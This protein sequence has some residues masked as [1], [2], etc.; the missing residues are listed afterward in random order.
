M[1]ANTVGR[2]HLRQLVVGA[3]IVALTLS[4]CSS[5]IPGT[6]TS[7]DVGMSAH[8][9][10][11]VSDPEGNPEVPLAVTLRGDGRF[12]VHADFP[13]GLYETYGPRTRSSCKW[14]RSAGTP[15]GPERIVDAGAGTERQVVLVEATDSIF[16]TEGCLPWQLLLR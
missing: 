16:Q 15:S 10:E 4:G 6:A 9:V 14:Q 12:V 8:S 3:P 2:E 11:W 7:S 13:P 1:S 5:N